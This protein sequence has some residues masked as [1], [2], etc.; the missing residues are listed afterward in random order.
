[1]LDAGPVKTAPLGTLPSE[2]DDIRVADRY[3]LDREIGRGGSGAVW[4]AHDEVLGR[5]VAIKRIGL[6][7]GAAS[8]DV[9]R[10]EREARISAQVNH[11]NVVSVFDF[12]NDGEH[13]WLVTEYVEG[14]TLAQL[15]RD[16]GRLTPDEAA[17][18]LLQVA[19]ALAAAHRLEIVHRDV[20][21]SN[22]LI[23]LDGTAKLSDFGIARAVA[24][25]SLT[26]TG[27]VTGSPAYL[28][29]EVA[30]GASATTSSDVWSFGATIYHALSGHPPYEATD[31]ENAVLAVLYRIAHEPPPKLRGGG[32]LAPLLETTMDPEPTH[33]LAMEDVV[34]YLR[35]GLHDSSVPVSP[36]PGTQ[37]LPLPDAGS[38]TS[39]LVREDSST[40]TAVAAPPPDDDRPSR[41]WLAVA[42]AAAAVI[43]LAV[44]GG[45]LLLGGEDDPEEEAA[46][47][48]NT[49]RSAG[50]GDGT[51]DSPPSD[52]A[53]TAEELESF[54]TSYVETA[55]DDPNAGFA[56]LTPGYQ[57]RSPEYADFWGP[58]SN[59][60]ILEIEADPAA[61]TVTYTYNYDYPGSGNQTERVTLFLVREGDQLLIDDAVSG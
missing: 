7:P 50:T 17:P 9:S 35:S 41:H 56:L 6:P 28:A 53:P 40:W 29:P 49:T 4:L 36:D 14:T 19:D 3:T 11:A 45:L 24:D 10:A 47:L 1:M 39:P 42:L 37:V 31:G 61:L 55:A 22:I 32:W 57:N 23:A 46:S 13:T 30:T 48:P 43:V 59:P 21:P 2:M 27:L 33:R 12:V 16:R 54:A 5:T 51:N 60:E 26:Q 15:I 18:L 52:S 58:M 38:T 20:K 8:Y 44:I 34:A 25:A